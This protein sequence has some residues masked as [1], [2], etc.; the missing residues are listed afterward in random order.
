MTS[1]DKQLQSQIPVVPD[2]KTLALINTY[3]ANTTKAM[4][5]LAA[6][7]E[8]NIHKIDRR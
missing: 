2:Q 8:H 4:N 3:I 6:S 5:H 7:C 1:E